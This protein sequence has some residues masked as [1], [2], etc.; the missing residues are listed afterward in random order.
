MLK[1][2]FFKHIPTTAIGHHIVGW[3][4]G[5]PIHKV[6]DHLWIIFKDVFFEAVL[7]SSFDSQESEP[8]FQIFAY[9]LVFQFEKLVRFQF[10]PIYCRLWG[11]LLLLHPWISSYSH[12]YVVQASTEILS[13]ICQSAPLP[14]GG[15]WPIHVSLLANFLC[16]HRQRNT[17][18]LIDY[19]IE[20]KKHTFKQCSAL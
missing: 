15:T 17:V 19:S 11:D 9:L 13:M 8:R 16:F 1:S 5:P 6:D 14:Y 2:K 10:L 18:I 4:I 3:V 12:M 7:K 20:F